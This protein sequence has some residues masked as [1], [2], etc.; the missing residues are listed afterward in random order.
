VHP[1]SHSLT[2]VHL[3]PLSVCIYKLHLGPSRSIALNHLLRRFTVHKFGAFRVCWRSGVDIVLNFRGPLDIMHMLKALVKSQ[4]LDL[5][6]FFFLKFVFSSGVQNK[7]FRNTC[8]ITKCALLGKETKCL[9][10]I[11]FSRRF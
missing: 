10:R 9:L 1:L 7:W 3:A 2:Q 6:H 5:H 8:L 4:H 11:L